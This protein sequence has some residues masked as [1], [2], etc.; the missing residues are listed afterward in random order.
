[1]GSE[2]C[3]AYIQVRQF[4]KEGFGGRLER[5][6]APKKRKETKCKK[7]GSQNDK[8]LGPQHSRV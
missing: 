1:M 6:V 8:S 2:A 3:P 4:Q 7:G 5:C